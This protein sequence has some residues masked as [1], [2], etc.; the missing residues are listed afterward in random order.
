M[1]AVHEP[2]EATGE[3][4]PLP[5]LVTSLLK[6]FERDDRREIASLLL[7]HRAS[8][9]ALAH[10]LVEER[11]GVHVASRTSE[12]S[13]AGAWPSAAWALLRDQWTDQQQRTAS[14]LAMLADVTD[15]LRASGIDHLVLK[16]LPLASRW[17]GGTGERFSWDLDLLVAES[18]V[19]PALRDLRAL[20]I[21]PPRATA[22]LAAVA[23]RVTHALECHRDDGLSLDLHWAFRRLPGVR[24]DAGRVFGDRQTVALD[25]RPCLVPSDDDTLTQVLLGIAADA[26][27]SLC[28]LRS[29]WDAYLLLRSRPGSGWTPYLDARR[30]DGTLGLVAAAVALVVH[31]LDASDELEEL[32]VGLDEE[33]GARFR[34]TAAEATEMLSRPPHSL[35]GHL[36]FAAWQPQPRWR[37]WAWWG[38]TLP[39][40]AYFARRR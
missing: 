17:Y 38:A 26:D 40:R 12:A 23:R 16:G 14:L 11:L 5:S 18:D 35:R 27:R 37:Y 22:P 4:P 24:F 39:A 7:R 2:G 13:L 25:G 28:R 30:A 20:G 1:S 32:L 8:L 9:E 36:D 31:R 10:A 15:R 19:V 6:A 3:G 34:L 33:A 21:R 29:V